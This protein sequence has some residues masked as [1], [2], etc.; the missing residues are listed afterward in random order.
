MRHLVG[1][2]ATRAERDRVQPG[3]RLGQ[4]ADIEH[5]PAGHRHETQGLARILLDLCR[6]DEAELELSRLSEEYDRLLGTD[7]L[8]LIK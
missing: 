8:A 1:I 2:G 6:F 4:S 3:P 7:A 5:G